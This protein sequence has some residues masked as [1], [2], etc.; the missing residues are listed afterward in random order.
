MQDYELNLKQAEMV[1]RYIYSY[2]GITLICASFSYVFL[3]LIDLL[4]RFLGNWNSLL[5]CRFGKSP[6]M[7]NVGQ[8]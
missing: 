3:C 1:I 5:E 2:D 4:I 7:L 6:K 8:K